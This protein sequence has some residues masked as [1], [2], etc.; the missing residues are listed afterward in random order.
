MVGYPHDIKGN[1][2][3]CYVS[4]N[5]NESSSEDLNKELKQTVRNKIWSFLGALLW[6]LGEAH[7]G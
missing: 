5:A 7:D 4:L 6:I 2:L 1:G 3:Y